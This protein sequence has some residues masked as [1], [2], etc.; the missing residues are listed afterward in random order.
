MQTSLLMDKTWQR[1]QTLSPISD[2][3]TLAEL[4]FSPGNSIGL[5]SIL[6]PLSCAF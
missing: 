3:R 6:V 2:A 5:F 4:L 1:D